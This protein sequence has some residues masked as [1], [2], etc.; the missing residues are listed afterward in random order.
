[1][2]PI[3]RFGIGSLT[4]TQ[5]ILAFVAFVSLAYLSGNYYHIWDNTKDRDFSLSDQSKKILASPTI[6]EREDPIQVTVA[7]RKDSVYFDRCLLYTSP[8]PRDQRG[9]RMPSS[10]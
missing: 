6:T 2:K 7:F 8:S 1:M 10:A 3:S 9:S 5:L 4:L